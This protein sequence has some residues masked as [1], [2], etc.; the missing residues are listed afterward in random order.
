MRL[1]ET[2]KP[3][4]N[5]E[6]AVAAALG[7]RV[8][9]G[10]PMS[11]KQLAAVLR[12]SEQHVWQMVNGHKAPSSRRLMDLFA[13]FGADFVH[14]VLIASVGIGAYDAR[15]V[16]ASAWV[17]SIKGAAAAV[18]AIAKLAPLVNEEPL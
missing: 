6:T 13:F 10:N 14:E 8:G 11:Y 16:K 5:V 9:P 2:I 1:V 4:T 17:S 15:D 18:R 7:K 12:S 3:K